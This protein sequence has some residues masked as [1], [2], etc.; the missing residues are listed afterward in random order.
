MVFLSCTVMIVVRFLDLYFACIVAVSQLA[1]ASC[2]TAADSFTV[3]S[4]CL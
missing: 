1:P 2:F 4:K 3:G